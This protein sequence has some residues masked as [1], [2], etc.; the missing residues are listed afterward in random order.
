MQE[1]PSLGDIEEGRSKLHHIRWRFDLG[2]PELACIL[3]VSASSAL[4]LLNGKAM[5][6][7]QSN[8]VDKLYNFVLWADAGYPRKNQSPLSIE[9]IEEYR[10]RLH[11][12]R[13]RFGLSFFEMGSMLYTSSHTVLALGSGKEPTPEQAQIIDELYDVV[14]WCD[15]GSV[16]HNKDK[17]MP[18]GFVHLV[19]NEY[20]ECKDLLG[21]GGYTPKETHPLSKEAQ[22]ARKPPRPEDLLDALQDPIH[23]DIV[24]QARAAKATKVYLKDVQDV[25]SNPFQ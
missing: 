15:T 20:Q 7:E 21:Y 2:F 13:N 3:G 5:T 17:L 10:K 8:I 18:E 16:T 19:N 12:I 1:A 6:S 23:S 25:V 14:L 9:A 22:D 11:Y 4:S 24:G